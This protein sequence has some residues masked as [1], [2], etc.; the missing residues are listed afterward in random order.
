MNQIC[1]LINLLFY[2]FIVYQIRW[3]ISQFSDTFG[4]FCVQYHVIFKEWQFFFYLSNL[5]SFYFFFFHDCHG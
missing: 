1:L 5:G 3:W 4:I 2:L